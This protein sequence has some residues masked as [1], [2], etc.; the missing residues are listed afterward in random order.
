MTISLLF[1]SLL[2]VLLIVTIVCA[3]ILNVR[4]RE[5]R[6]GREEME[7]ML[8]RFADA[9]ARAQA[10]IAGLKET[11]DAVARPLKAELARG[12][13][14]RDELA[15]LTERG[16]RLSADLAAPRAR[17][18]APADGD[19]PAPSGRSPETPR[20]SEKPRP[21]APPR[22]AETGDDAPVPF[23]RQKAPR[24]RETGAARR[25]PDGAEA[26]SAAERQ[27]LR[28]LRAAR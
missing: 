28:A 14:L 23:I 13:A 6:R 4:L 9:T 16:A 24:P 18:T 20:L 5:V 21:A 19:R 7:A 11:E 8:G 25:D 10:A 2:A 12:R 1:D 3:A 27:L 22:P 15:F 26:R 17:A